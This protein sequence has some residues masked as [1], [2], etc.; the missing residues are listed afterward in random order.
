[1]INV[2][3]IIDQPKYKTI[4]SKP[5][6][7]AASL[8]AANFLVYSSQV[9]SVSPSP[10]KKIGLTVSGSHVSYLRFTDWQPNAPESKKSALSR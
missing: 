6:A 2:S 4:Y 1:M 5:T 8:L 9:N 10:K 7:A 3:P